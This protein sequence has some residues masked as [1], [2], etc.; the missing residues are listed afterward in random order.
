[1]Q[2]K[3]LQHTK[4]EQ[5]WETYTKNTSQHTKKGTDLGKDTT[6]EHKYAFVI[7]YI[8]GLKK[9]PLTGAQ[10]DMHGAPEVGH[11]ATSGSLT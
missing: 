5:T 6:N 9:V 1:M 3:S 11:L 8:K 7:Q 4:K 10:S 2:N